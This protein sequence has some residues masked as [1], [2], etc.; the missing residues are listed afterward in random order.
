MYQ[1]LKRSMESLEEQVYQ[2]QTAQCV[3]SSK[4]EK[5]HGV[6][7]KKQQ[8]ILQQVTFALKLKANLKTMHRPDAIINLGL[9]EPLH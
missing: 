7:G 2:S 8:K 1:G 9:H 5:E 4:A 3:H 6:E